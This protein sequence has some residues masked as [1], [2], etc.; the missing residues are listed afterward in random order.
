MAFISLSYN[1]SGR[2]VTG[3]LPALFLEPAGLQACAHAWIPVP[4][5]DQEAD[6]RR[7]IEGTKMGE[8]YSPP[9]FRPRTPVFPLI[10]GHTG[11]SNHY[12]PFEEW[13]AWNSEMGQTRLGFP[14][15]LSNTFGKGKVKTKKNATQSTYGGSLYLPPYFSLLF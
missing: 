5:P 12:Y 4:V 8:Y 15:P 3:C 14:K 6:F 7:H 11:G 13:K 10:G 1:E 2:R 9:L